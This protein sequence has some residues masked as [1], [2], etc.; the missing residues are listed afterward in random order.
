MAKYE[1][2]AHPKSP[3]ELKFQDAKTAL[4]RV[5]SLRSA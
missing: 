5:R 4:N 3:Q 2:S 1:W